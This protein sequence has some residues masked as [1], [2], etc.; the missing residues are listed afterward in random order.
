M[1]VLVASNQEQSNEKENMVTPKVSA[2]F[3][4]TL[5]AYL[6]RRTR[7]VIQSMSLSVDTADCRI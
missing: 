6:I 1:S 2:C 4:P 7:Q 5:P 3:L